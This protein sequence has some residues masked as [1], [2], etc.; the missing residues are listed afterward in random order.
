MGF[1]VWW[2]SRLPRTWKVPD[3]NPGRNMVY[4][5]PTWKSSLISI[6]KKPLDLSIK[7]FDVLPGNQKTKKYIISSTRV[8]SYPGWNFLGIPCH[9]CKKSVCK[10]DKVDIRIRILQSTP[11]KRIPIQNRFVFALITIFRFQNPKL[12]VW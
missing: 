5:F 9:F 3:S 1:V 7:L 8:F 6:S 11:K 2:L 12:S 10:E 4:F